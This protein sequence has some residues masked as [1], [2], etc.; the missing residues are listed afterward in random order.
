[1]MHR[2]IF[3][4]LLSAILPLAL[5]GCVAAPPLNEMPK[6]AVLAPNFSLSH[7]PQPPR[8]A[9]NSDQAYTLAELI[10]IAQQ[11]NPTTRIA[12]LEAEQAA[13]AAGLVKATY[14]PMITASVIGG[15]QRSKWTSEVD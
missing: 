6:K 13:L 11:N 12:W 15:Y 8:T 3:S 7:I 2:T 4:H 10:D 1:M 9:I 5:A 14:L